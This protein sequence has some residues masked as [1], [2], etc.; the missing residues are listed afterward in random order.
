VVL[1]IGGDAY[2]PASYPLTMVVSRKLRNNVGLGTKR[3][4]C[5]EFTCPVRLLRRSGYYVS[6]ETKDWNMNGAGLLVT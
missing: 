4:L 3:Q 6:L 1:P 5:S 2:Q